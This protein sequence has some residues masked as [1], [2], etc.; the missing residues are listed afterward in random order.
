MPTRRLRCIRPGPWRGDVHRMA[1]RALGAAIVSEAA[2]PTGLPVGHGL[3][4][5]IRAPSCLLLCTTALLSSLS[6]SCAAVSSSS[7]SHSV[8]HPLAQLISANL[9][10]QPPPTFT[11]HAQAHS[12]RY[13]PAPAT[14]ERPAD[15][16]QFFVSHRC[17]GRASD[18]AEISAAHSTRPSPPCQDDAGEAWTDSSRRPARPRRHAG[19]HLLRPH[20]HGAVHT[21]PL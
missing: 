11:Y 5:W 18:W 2:K 13:V 10:E 6:T 4:G 16:S 15:A 14:C 17:G 9:V 7:A 1:R 3:L 19:A 21:H 8:S 20:H 12:F